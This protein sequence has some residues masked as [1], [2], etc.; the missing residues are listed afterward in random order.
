MSPVRAVFLDFGGT[1]ADRQPSEWSILVRTC[2]E[3]GRRL[4]RR[5]IDHGRMLADRSHRSIQ[6][7]TAEGMD[8]FW[9]EWFRLIL[10]NLGV[11]D[12]RAIA[13][14]TYARMGKETSVV[15][16]DDVMDALRALEE[17]DL[18][19]GVVSNFNCILEARC[20]RLGIADY[21]DFILASDLIGS[22]KPKPLIFNL[23]VA[24]AGFQAGECIHVGDSYGADYMGARDA[25]LQALLLNRSGQE[26]GQDCPTIS[27]L[28]GIVEY[29]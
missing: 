15:L 14:E 9:P 17:R 20:R 4:T 13:E 7:L 11:D 25:G 6:F 26:V 28:G 22:G 29:L 1:L 19:L 8:F 12:S 3:H 23:A 27:D 10:A 21:F 24:E 5:E 18:C 16:Y 2:A